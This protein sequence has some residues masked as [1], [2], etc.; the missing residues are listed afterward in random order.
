MTFSI[1]RRTLKQGGTP[2]TERVS[3]D[4]HYINNAE[5]TA[6]VG[7]YNK[8][9]KQRKEN[10]EPIPT[11]PDFVG[12]SFQRIA[13]FMS[14]KPN[15]SGY[16]FKDEMISDAVLNCCNYITRFDADKYSNAFAYFSQS[17]FF[18]FLLRIK[19]EKGQA[20]VKASLASSYST[21]L[22]ELFLEMKDSEL[23][24]KNSS[25]DLIVSHSSNILEEHEKSVTKQRQKRELKTKQLTRDIE[26]E[27]STEQE[28]E[29]YE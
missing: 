16:S 23:D 20:L 29:T 2:K 12:V 6:A 13:V 3:A 15:F 26:L 18:S 9:Y 19:K 21:I 27:M 28:V 5:F 22:D 4:F 24:F 8:L 17:T 10:G 11:I 1:K 14:K 25:L 7:A